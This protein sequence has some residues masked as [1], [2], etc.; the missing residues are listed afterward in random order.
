MGMDRALGRGIGFTTWMS[1]ANAPNAKVNSS[2]LAA[3]WLLI[4]GI[5]GSGFDIRTQAARKQDATINRKEMAMTPAACVAS[6]RPSFAREMGK[7]RASVNIN[8][9]LEL[10]SNAA[11]AM[12]RA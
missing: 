2:Q 3:S 9:A 11:P 12:L 8:G 1:T 10:P 6:V 7:R 4:S 5:D